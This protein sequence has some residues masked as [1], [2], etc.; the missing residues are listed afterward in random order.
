MIVGIG[1]GIPFIQNKIAVAVVGLFYIDD[2]AN[3]YVDDLG[4]TYID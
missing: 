1:I 4:N 3:S 2:L